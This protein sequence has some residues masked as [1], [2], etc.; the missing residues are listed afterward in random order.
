MVIK[1]DSMVPLPVW[2]RHY[3]NKAAAHEPLHNRRGADRAQGT[4]KR[5]KKAGLS[6]SF[7]SVRRGGG[8]DLN[9]IVKSSVKPT[10][11]YRR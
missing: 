4:K 7:M 1:C 9:Q 10:S 8:S 2:E 6:L 5:E 11:L 3:I